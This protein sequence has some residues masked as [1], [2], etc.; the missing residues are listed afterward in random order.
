M[1]RMA[2]VGGKGTVYT[3]RNRLQA[4]DRCNM[5]GFCCCFA[6]SIWNRL[7]IYIGFDIFDCSYEDF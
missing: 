3:G 1:L 2:G 4:R 5:E 6:P 7:Y